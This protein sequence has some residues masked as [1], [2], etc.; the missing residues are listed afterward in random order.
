MKCETCKHWLV[1]NDDEFNECD[2]AAG[3]DGHAMD[4]TS[5]AYAADRE[6]Y[7]AWLVTRAN[8]GCVQWEAKETIIRGGCRTG[9]TA[10]EPPKAEPVHRAICHKCKHHR[11][12][13]ASIEIGGPV[14]EHQCRV[15]PD[16]VDPITGVGNAALCYAFNKGG[17]CHLYEAKD[18]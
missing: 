17:D 15:R 10:T 7:S 16:V 4:D 1:H 14:W 9:K 2:R 18:E 5:L 8:F 6:Q 11:P 13:S 12:F 3:Q